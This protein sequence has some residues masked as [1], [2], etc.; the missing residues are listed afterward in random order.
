VIAQIAVSAA[1]YAMDK[2]YDYLVPPDLETRLQPGMRVTVPFGRGNRRQEGMVLALLPGERDGLKT[3]EQILDDAPI[4]D[5]QFLRLAAFLRERYFCTFYD[6]VRAI[7]PAGVWFSP[8]QTY[9]I[10]AAL[11]EN[12]QEKGAAHSLRAQ[13]IQAILDLGGTATLTALR[14]Y[15]PEEEPLR[16]TLRELTAKGYLSEEEELSRR[17]REK[18]E[19]MVLLAAEPDEAM[20]YATKRRKAAPQQAAVLELLCTIGSGSLKEICYFTGAQATTVRR[21]AELGFLELRSE[22]VQ[23]RPEIHAAETPR[24]MTLNE[25]QEAAYQGLRAQMKRE[26]PGTALL[27]GVTGSGKTAVYLHLISDCLADGKSAMLLVPEIALTP[28]LLS[29]FAAHFGAQV[30]VMHSSLR[31]GE[32][33]DEWKRIRS[34]EARVVIGTRSAVFAPVQNLG[35]LLLDEEQEHTYKS[36][37]APRYHAREVAIFRGVQEN[38]LVVLGS[39]T[40]SIETMYRA[41]SGVYTL[42]TLRRRFNGRPLPAV[43]ITDLKAEIRSGNG[44]ALGSA[45]RR[46]IAENL[47]SGHQ[48]ILF[49][50][51]RGSSRLVVCVDCGTVPECPRCS[52]S[53]TYHAAN[54]RLMCHHCGYSEPLPSRC[55]ACG[56]PLK[57]VGT[58]TQRVQEELEQLWP[59][60][61]TIR[62]DADTISAAHP[63]EEMLRR[64]ETEKIPVL[65]G[66]QM[67]AKGLDFENVTLVGVLDADQSLYLSHF[68]A[69]ET[70]FSMLAQVIGRAGRGMAAGKAVIQTMTPEHPVIQLSAAQDYDAFYDAEIRLRQLRGVP[71]FA[72][73][74]TL[75][76]SGPFEDRVI[77]GAM[78]FRQVL[79][80]QLRTPTYCREAVQILGPAPAPI[81]KINNRF[82]HRL[83]LG[84]K[85]TRVLR[86]LLAY[87]LREFA[88]DRTNKGVTAWADVNAYE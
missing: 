44:T 43:E 69:A 58:G 83:T 67:V 9:R 80:A 74:I 45:V 23:R 87:L 34:G 20:S 31:L 48:T 56:G 22:I 18:T 42:Y 25:E 77:D 50:N 85:N 5:E 62:M 84:C 32:R 2:P 52:V 61:E 12:W 49:L 75:T 64:F 53:L 54:H 65:I 41:K 86:Q 70:T 1:V 63:H 8:K 21:L 3:V 88:R 51:R 55:P 10:T 24:E 78:R 71:P 81:V 46:G 4:L 39:A 73:E 36:E 57:P 47:E 76:F 29:L 17:M 33:Y 13:V 27:Y 35:L 40:P 72:D 6:A 11:P 59:E 68:R 82:R 16:R 26:K 60:M 15:F 7:L 79:E 14:S 66:T 28:Q 30:A 37:N 38:A 19:Q